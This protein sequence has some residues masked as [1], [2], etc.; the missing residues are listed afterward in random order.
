MTTE[1][2]LDAAYAIALSSAKDHFHNRAAHLAE[3][4]ENQRQNW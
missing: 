3:Q 2:F 1:V 4:L